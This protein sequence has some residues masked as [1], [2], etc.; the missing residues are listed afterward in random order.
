MGLDIE[1][2]GLP[3]QYATGGELG[4]A[5]NDTVNAAWGHSLSAASVCDAGMASIKLSRDIFRAV[6]AM[7]RGFAG[8]AGSRLR[9]GP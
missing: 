6:M 1:V 4:E 2:Q 5:A 9:T 3:P 7:L 8:V